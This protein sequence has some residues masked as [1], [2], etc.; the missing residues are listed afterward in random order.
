[1][2]DKNE[3]LIIDEL[4][5][6]HPTPRQEFYRQMADAPWYQ[7]DQRMKSMFFR[8]FATGFAVMLIVVLALSVSIPTVRASVL[9][10]LGLGVSSSDTVPNPAVQPNDLVDSQKVD[11]ISQLAGWQV[12]I[13]AW[14]PA[15]YQFKDA[16]YDST[17]KMAILTFM[18]TRPLPGA[19]ASLTETKALTF[20]QAKRNDIIPLMVAPSTSVLDITINGQPAAFAM[21]AWENDISTGQATWSNAYPLQNVY[22]QIEDV[23]LYLNTEDSLLTKE[24]LLKTA[25]SI[26]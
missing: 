3:R 12:K 6:Y 24:D 11:E 20:I 25:E 18:A 16:I 26:K 1:M 2:N 21:G 13:P 22:W 5:K 7:K 15:E 14:L 17:N 9:S 19:D 10:F 4:Q 23:Y 8:R